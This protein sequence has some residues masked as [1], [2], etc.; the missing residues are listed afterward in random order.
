[1]TT[2]I[3]AQNGARLKPTVKVGV[4]GCKKPRKPKRHKKK[5]HKQ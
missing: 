3:T 5:R 1:M 2:A 4:E